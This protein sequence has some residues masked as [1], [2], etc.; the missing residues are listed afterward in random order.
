MNWGNF[1]VIKV[2]KNGNDINIEAEFLPDDKNFKDT[3]KMGWLC[4][5]SPLV[6]YFFI[7]I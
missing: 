6:N 1:K 4:S 2:N 5:D 7:S 3:K